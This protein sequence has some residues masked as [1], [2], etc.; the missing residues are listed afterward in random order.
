MEKLT[1]PCPESILSEQLKR[2]E[3]RYLSDNVWGAIKYLYGEDFV[4]RAPTREVKAWTCD[5]LDDESRPYQK[6]I[7]RAS[8]L[9]V[10]KRRNMGAYPLIQAEIDCLQRLASM[11]EIFEDNPRDHVFLWMRTSF[12]FDPSNKF[13]SQT[14]VSHQLRNKSG[15]A[16]RPNRRDEYGLMA[17]YSKGVARNLTYA[18]RAVVEAVLTNTLLTCD[19]QV[20]EVEESVV[21]DFKKP[22]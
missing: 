11:S 14:F 19:L 2:A 7:L 4:K 22:L 10:P 20:E 13:G 8:S 18:D 3:V 12:V 6:N 1:A 15:V 21:L 5:W 17:D 16:V 9:I